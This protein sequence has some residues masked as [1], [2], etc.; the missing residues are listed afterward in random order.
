MVFWAISC[1]KGGGGPRGDGGGEG[2]RGGRDDGG[3]EGL[4]GARP[5][6]GE[7]GTGSSGKGGHTASRE[8]I[9]GDGN[10][11]VQGQQGDGLGKP[12][13]ISQAGE[14]ELTPKERLVIKDE[15]IETFV[16]HI[17]GKEKTS[18]T[19]PEKMAKEIKAIDTEIQR[20]EDS[21]K[22]IDIMNDRIILRRRIQKLSEARDSIRKV[23]WQKLV[24]EKVELDK[25]IDR[26]ESEFSMQAISKKSESS[27]KAKVIEKLK[28]RVNEI[29]DFLLYSMKPEQ[30][31]YS[32]MQEARAYAMR[33]SNLST[34][35]K[36]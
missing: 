6:D 8:P 13:N 7:H 2:P 33:R 36:K 30:R 34:L 12:V 31:T 24:P 27:K 26:L 11:K 25:E 14:F 28:E 29:S 15:E 5:G 18:S 20:L 9:G 3:G 22:K 23:M 10:L 19:S 21:I 4:E 16:Y 32:K 17:R 35:S 1:Q